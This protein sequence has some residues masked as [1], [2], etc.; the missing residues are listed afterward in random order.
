VVLKDLCTDI[1][2]TMLQ[3]CKSLCRRNESTFKWA[4]C[5]LTLKSNML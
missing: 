3:I 4:Y 1:V 5:I 2:L